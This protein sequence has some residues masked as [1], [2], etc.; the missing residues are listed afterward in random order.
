MSEMVER[1]MR[2]IQLAEETDPEGR[3]FASPVRGDLEALRTISRAAIEAMRQ[4]PDAICKVG[5]DL[6]PP[7]EIEA[8][9][10]IWNAMIDAVLRPDLP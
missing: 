6:L 9:A 5:D 1:V 8:A 4:P 2:A 3:L 7:D 10:N